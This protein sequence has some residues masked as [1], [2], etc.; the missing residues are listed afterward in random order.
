MNSIPLTFIHSSTSQTF[1]ISVD[2]FTYAYSTLRFEF[3]DRSF[4]FE[5]NY[6]NVTGPHFSIV[7]EPEIFSS[8]YHEVCLILGRGPISAS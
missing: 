3:H 7:L 6:L 5:C 1:S 4:N 2:E 8:F